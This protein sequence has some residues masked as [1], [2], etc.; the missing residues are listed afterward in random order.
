MECEVELSYTQ[1]AAAVP[2]LEPDEFISHLGPYFFVDPFN[3]I[4]LSTHIIGSLS[5]TFSN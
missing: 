2:Y 1:E 5:L 3:I 4:L